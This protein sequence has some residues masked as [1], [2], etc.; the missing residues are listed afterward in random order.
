MTPDQQKLFKKAFQALRSARVLFDTDDMEGAIN[1][2]YYAVFYSAQAALLRVN[3]SP[4]THTGVHNRFFVH[5]VSEGPLS[6]DMGRILHYA[7]RLTEWRH[8]EQYGEHCDI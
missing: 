7:F 1:R 2:V 5:F 3:E 4:H 6:R 8:G